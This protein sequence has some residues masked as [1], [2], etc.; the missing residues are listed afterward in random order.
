MKIK[1]VDDGRAVRTRVGR[2]GRMLIDVESAVGK[3]YDGRVEMPYAEVP[4]REIRDGESG[5]CYSHT[6]EGVERF[7][8]LPPRP[9]HVDGSPLSVGRRGG[10]ETS[11][12]LPT[13]APRFYIELLVEE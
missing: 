5:I 3:L 4:V 7:Y 9:E 6:Y 11:L 10:W 13:P 8:L 12:A 2:N 1:T